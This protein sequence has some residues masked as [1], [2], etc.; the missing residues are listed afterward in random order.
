MKSLIG[1][2][3]FAV[4]L[5]CGMATLTYAADKMAAPGLQS[6]EGDLLKIEGEFYTVHDT[7]GHEVRM[8]VDKTTKLDGAFKTPT[9]RSVSESGPYFH[10]GRAAT[11]EDAVDFMLR[12]GIKNPNLDEKLKPRK[13]TAQERT[14]LLAFM[15]SLTP[16]PKPFE[17]PQLP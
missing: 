4:I 3:V 9:I 5:G 7:A 14:H 12:G 2:I 8:H 1:L 15:K 17:K 10:D 16:E 6:I 11:L 13:L